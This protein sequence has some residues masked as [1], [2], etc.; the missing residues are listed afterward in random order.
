[1][2]KTSI[3][4]I[5]ILVSGFLP[6]FTQSSTTDISKTLKVWI[7]DFTLYAD[8]ENISYLHI[9]EEDI[10]DY[11][12]FQMCIKVPKGLSLQKV[13]IGRN[14]YDAIATDRFTESHSITCNMVDDGTLI[15][16]AAL[17]MSNNLLFP[18]DE[19]GNPLLCS[20]ALTADPSMINGEY[21]IIM[22]DIKFIMPTS[23]AYIPESTNCAT[24]TH[25][26]R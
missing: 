20:L 13:T 21:D 2:K 15:K 18:E 1:M 10:V 25:S 24:L 7:D 8:G 16:I 12:A 17:S 9:S 3:A 22:D 5:Y 11:T 14:T 6:A 19:N 23:F 26:R 4:F